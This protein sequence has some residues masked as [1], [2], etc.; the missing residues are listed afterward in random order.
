MSKY[1]FMNVYGNIYIYTFILCNTYHKMPHSV[2]WHWVQWIVLQKLLIIILSLS[3]S[4]VSI[5]LTAN[6]CFCCLQKYWLFGAAYF[7]TRRKYIVNLSESMFATRMTLAVSS[8]MRS[9]VNPT[10]DT[11]HL[12]ITQGSTLN[13]LMWCRCCNR[14]RFQRSCF[15]MYA[16]NDYFVIETNRYALRS[17]LWK[18]VLMKQ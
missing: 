13:N 10:P 1:I 12:H 5:R 17:H 3:F 15:C 2:I 7:E 16:T 4:S 6:G 8:P 11:P 9:Q 18:R 14:D